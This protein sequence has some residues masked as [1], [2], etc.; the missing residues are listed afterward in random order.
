MTEIKQVI[1]NELKDIKCS[2]EIEYF[3][4]RYKKYIGKK[5]KAVLASITVFIICAA[6]VAAVIFSLDSNKSVQSDTA[7]TNNRSPFFTVYAAEIAGGDNETQILDDK[8]IINPSFRFEAHEFEN[9]DGKIYKTF[10]CTGENFIGVKGNGIEEIEF[11]SEKECLVD[12][13]QSGRDRVMYKFG[14]SEY[15]KTAPDT[16]YVE[17]RAPKETSYWM[18]KQSEPDY[19]FQFSDIPADTVTIGVKFTNGTRAQK[20]L[21]LSFNDE[22]YLVIKPL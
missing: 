9:G 22:G 11:L 21:S 16:V 18:E 7:G 3:Q 15:N 20:K 6:S 12:D 17:W 8:A 2:T 4:N 10:T 13:E 19:D 14:E 5:R 1:D